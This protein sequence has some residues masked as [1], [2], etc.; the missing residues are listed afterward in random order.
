MKKRS[1][2]GCRKCRPSVSDLPTAPPTL[3]PL[4]SSEAGHHAP[5]T[6]P[7]TPPSEGR[8]CSGESEGVPRIGSREVS[9]PPSRRLVGEEGGGAA[10]VLASGGASN[11]AASSLP[12]VGVAGSS[13]SQESIMLV[14]PS[15]VASSASSEHDRRSRFREVEGS[16]E[17]CSRSSRSSPSR[18]RDSHGE[19]SCAH[20]RSGGLHAWSR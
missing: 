19:R 13:R 6:C 14:A 16:T 1:Y 20:S 4:A 11:S 15:S 3:P 17:D 18:G 5:P 7:P 9:S 10:W 8:S 12:G 2:S